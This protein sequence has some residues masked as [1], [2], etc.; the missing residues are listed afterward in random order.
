MNCRDTA[1]TLSVDEALV[2]LEPYYLAV[3]ER[4]LEVGLSRC[5]HTQ[6][7]IDANGVIHTIVSGPVDEQGARALIESMLPASTE[8]SEVPSGS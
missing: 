5:K 2:V 4:F 1:T 8:T 6:F 7:F 3:R